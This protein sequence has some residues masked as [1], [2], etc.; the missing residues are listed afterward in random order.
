MVL[1]L[2]YAKSCLIRI[3]KERKFVLNSKPIQVVSCYL[4]ANPIGLLIFREI[5]KY[6]DCF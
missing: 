2:I 5:K 6:H 3:A 4:E 1:V